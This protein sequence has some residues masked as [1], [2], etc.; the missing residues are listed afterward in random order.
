MATEFLHFNTDFLDNAPYGA[1]I[2]DLDQTIRYWNSGAERIL[3][4]LS[5]N[6][7]GRYCYQALQNLHP[8][9]SLEV[10]IRGC[11]SLTAARE[12]RIAGV[13]Q[14]R[15][16]S[17]SGDRKLVTLTPMVIPA[18]GPEGLILVHLFHEGHNERD[19]LR[20]AGAVEGVLVGATSEATKSGNDEESPLTNREMEVLRLMA[21]GLSNRFIASQ[22]GVSYHTVRNQVSSIRG[23]L[24]VRKRYDAA[25]IGRVLG[26]S[27]NA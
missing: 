26:L 7:V 18:D 9:H 1:Y 16:L 3:G 12:G 20:V 27:D 15:M 2:V 5:V 21:A 22:L 11:V 25:R 8:E 23:K 24:N 6:M 17:A 13:F 4:H 10:C 19:A 14:V